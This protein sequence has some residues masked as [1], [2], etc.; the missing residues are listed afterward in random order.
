MKKVNIKMKKV[1]LFVSTCL[2]V[3]VV[4]LQ[5]IFLSFVKLFLFLFLLSSAW[6]H[7]SELL[8]PGYFSRVGLHQLE[9]KIN[10]MNTNNLENN[11]NSRYKIWNYICSMN[12][13]KSWLSPDM[14]PCS[15]LDPISVQVPWI[16][17]TYLFWN[18]LS[19]ASPLVLWKH[20]NT[21][22][23]QKVT[24]GPFPFFVQ[25]ISEISQKLNKWKRISI[26]F[27]PISAIFNFFRTFLVRFR[28]LESYTFLVFGSV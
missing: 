25:E 11:F 9:R 21:E 16:V 27:W 2:L 26:Y 8:G 6:E 10:K 1:I 19:S 7:P 22:T 4:L 12:C 15:S 24:Y 14:A 3:L 23:G 5:H 18:L 13:Q 20:L 17:D 28:C